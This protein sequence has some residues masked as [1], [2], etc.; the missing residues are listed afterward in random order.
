MFV[1]GSEKQR[2]QLAAWFR[3]PLGTLDALI[4]WGLTQ[5]PEELY[6]K[7]LEALYLGD[8]ELARKLLVVEGV[9][10][11]PLAVLHWMQRRNEQELKRELEPLRSENQSL[12]EKIRE[13]EREL[14]PEPDLDDPDG[15][16]QEEDRQ[17]LGAFFPS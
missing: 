5:P 11:A 2:K 15:D 14:Y 6:R 1:S 17:A 13:L 9:H 3:G 7:A 4:Q 8:V 12:R 10:A 16:P